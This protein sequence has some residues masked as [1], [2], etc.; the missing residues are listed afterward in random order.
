MNFN[1]KYQQEL[2]LSV[3]LALHIFDTFVVWEAGPIAKKAFS[4]LQE[5]YRRFT[6]LEKATFGDAIIDRYLGSL[7]QLSSLKISD[8]YSP[9]KVIEKLQLFQ[10]PV[11]TLASKLEKYLNKPLTLILIKLITSVASTHG[12]A[13]LEHYCVDSGKLLTQYTLLELSQCS[14]KACLWVLDHVQGI[15]QQ[16]LADAL[17]LLLLFLSGEVDPITADER[18][19]SAK[20][21]IEGLN[22]QSL[23]KLVFLTLK[24]KSEALKERIN[25]LFTVLT[26]NLTEQFRRSA[27][28]MVQQIIARES[29]SIYVQ[30]NQ[31]DLT[32]EQWM[33]HLQTTLELISLTKD[34]VVLDEPAALKLLELPLTPT[35]WSRALSIIPRTHAILLAIIRNFP[36][37]FY[38]SLGKDI[39]RFCEPLSGMKSL[40]STHLNWLDLMR[41]LKL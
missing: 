21:F 5:T 31:Q 2:R 29:G 24:L 13:N 33:S 14:F 39:A 8:R 4:F 38:S 26:A 25:K 22:E 36:K 35:L 6:N 19:S 9:L 28:Q 34:S 41:Q 12:I 18:V 11:G 3:D 30:I 37:E 32:Q 23:W 7:D 1:R 17:D 20:K 16:A 40:E 27:N 15:R 10:L